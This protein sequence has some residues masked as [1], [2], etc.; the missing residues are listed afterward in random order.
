MAYVHAPRA[1]ELNIA[2][3]LHGTIE[4]FKA[5]RARRAAYNRVYNELALLTDRDLADIGIVRSQIS[6]IAHQEAAKI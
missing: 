2:H 5:F 1:L 6:E 4:G 3:R